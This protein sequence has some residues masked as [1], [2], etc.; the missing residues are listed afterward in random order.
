MPDGQGDRS[1]QALAD[2][3]TFTVCTAHQPNIFTGHLYFIF[4]IL[5]RS[6]CLEESEQVHTGATF[7]PGVLYG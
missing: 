5:T 7:V 1:D 4:K 3:H 2:E 6:A